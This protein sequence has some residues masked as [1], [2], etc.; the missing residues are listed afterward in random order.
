MLQAQEVVQAAC[1]PQR[2]SEARSWGREM[3]GGGGGGVSNLE[4]RTMHD[5]TFE[6]AVPH[7]SVRARKVPRHALWCD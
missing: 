6:P 2:P 4:I 3:E 7:N 5:S 1:Q